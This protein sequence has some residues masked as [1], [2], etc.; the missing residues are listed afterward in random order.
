MEDYSWDHKYLQPLF[1]PLI[2][3]ELL[4]NQL[5]SQSVHYRVERSAGVFKHSLRYKYDEDGMLAKA[6]LSASFRDVQMARW[7]FSN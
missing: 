6:S 1:W 5:T 3:L 7:Q 4:I 2:N